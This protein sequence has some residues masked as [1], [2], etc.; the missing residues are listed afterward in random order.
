MTPE[1]TAPPAAPAARRA[2]SPWVWPLRV[3]GVV[4]VAA[5]VAA[6]A[7]SLVVQFFVREARARAVVDGVRSVEATVTSGAISV[8]AGDP[9]TGVVVESVR[10]SAFRTATVT[11]EVTD[12]RLVLSGG[13]GSG[14]LLDDQCSV[15][16]LLEVPPGT[17]L[18]L[19]TSAGDVDVTGVDGAVDVRTTVGDVTLD[20]VRA[21]TVRVTTAAGD[22]DAELAL[23]PQAVR[24]RSGVG[25][26][27]V[28][29]PDAPGGYRV[30]A[31]TSVGTP[32]VRV[33][34]SPGSG[35]SLDLATTAGDVVLRPAG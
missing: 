28:A 1:V 16:L 14:P 22:V 32:D 33:P 2:P 18:T 29:V 15:D 31:D 26:V 17:S 35:R 11:R 21:Q 6:G 25:D 12:G 3:V 30:T 24:V 19:R 4:L 10:R 9:G 34:D 23:A 27:T 8:T 5:L 20:G 7:G 13:C